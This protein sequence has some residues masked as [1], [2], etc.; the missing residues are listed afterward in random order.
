MAAAPDDLVELTTRPNELDAAIIRQ[1]LTDAGIESWQRMADGARLGMFGASNFN[2]TTVLVERGK[3]E[4]AAAAL[5]RNKSDSVDLDWT[6][7]DV[8]EPED[9]IAKRIASQD[10]GYAD[11]VAEQRRKPLSIFEWC[12]LG[13]VLL[14]EAALIVWQRG[15][16]LGFMIMWVAMAGV[17]CLQKSSARTR[18]SEHSGARKFRKRPSAE[19]LLWMVFAAGA[20]CMVLWPAFP[21]HQLVSFKHTPN[22]PPVQFVLFYGF[23]LF[24]AVCLTAGLFGFIRSPARRKQQQD[25]SNT[26]D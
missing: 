23:F 9:E 5:D 13:A 7:V 22:P 24:I 6:E 1:V 17:I 19:R 12:V 18:Q 14:G 3:L 10:K 20:W 2:P 15:P 21:P 26:D 4:A 11:A 16:G 25:L 8:G